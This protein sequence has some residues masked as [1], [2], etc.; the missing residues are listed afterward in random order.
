MTINLCNDRNILIDT[1]REL[2]QMS[3]LNNKTSRRFLIWR[4]LYGS[5]IG[6]LS[7]SWIALNDIDTGGQPGWYMLIL[8]FIPT[9]LVLVS[10]KVIKNSVYAFA[11]THDF[12]LLALLIVSLF[13]L[14]NYLALI[15]LS[16]L[17]VFIIE[18]FVLM[19]GSYTGQ[20]EQ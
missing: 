16:P 20:Q 17:Y 10:A 7:I 13:I 1:N 5:L 19:I 14:P 18:G 8:G 3:V 9:V 15:L 12:I 6:L 11:L 2:P 4:M